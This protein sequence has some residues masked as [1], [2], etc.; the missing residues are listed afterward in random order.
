MPPT[1]WLGAYSPIL[2]QSCSGDDAD[3]RASEVGDDDFLHLFQAVSAAHAWEHLCAFA[4]EQSSGGFA[5]PAARTSD[6]EDFVCNI[7]LCGR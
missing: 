5:D 2:N 7:R 1:I 3:Y 6:E 4:G